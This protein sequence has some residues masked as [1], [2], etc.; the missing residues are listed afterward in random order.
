VRRDVEALRAWSDRYQGAARR[1]ARRVNDT[2]L[3]SQGHADGVRSYG[4]VVDLLL[5]ERRARLAA[6]RG[7]GS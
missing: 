1:V 2:Y 6:A 7:A 3:K 4:R 5:A